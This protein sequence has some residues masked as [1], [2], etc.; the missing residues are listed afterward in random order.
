[1]GIPR[2]SKL[3][4]FVAAAVLV[5]GACTESTGLG[6]GYGEVRVSL[7]QASD[8][9]LAQVVAAPD[10]LAP[11]G[12]AGRVPSDNVASLTIT[13]NGVQLLPYCEEA[14]EQNGDPNGDGQCE[15]LWVVLDIENE[16]DWVTLDLMALPSEGDSPLVFAAGDVPVGE[17]HKV[18]LFIS[19]A[20]V[21]FV[22]GFTVGRS[23]FEAGVPIPVEI[24]S[25]QNSGV[26][27]DISL[28]V[29]EGNVEDV[30][31]LFDSEATFKHVVGTGNGRVLMPPV[32]KARPMHQEQNGDG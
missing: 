32:I 10:A 30:G 19:E 29:E 9:I 31:L 5:A 25:A 7:G 27:A 14:G 4:A 28:V 6:D 3:A 23:D 21:E 20:W 26:K 13:V 17:Y 1:M 2:T 11:D 24:P 12:S 15:D 16:E 8:A 18:R 22:N